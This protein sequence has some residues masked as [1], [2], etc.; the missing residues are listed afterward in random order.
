MIPFTVLDA[1]VDRIVGKVG[2][3]VEVSRSY[4]HYSCGSKEASYRLYIANTMNGNYKSVQELQAA[5]ENI[6]NPPEDLGVMV[7]E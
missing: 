1:I 2:E 3:H 4:N 5:M 6:I 7:E